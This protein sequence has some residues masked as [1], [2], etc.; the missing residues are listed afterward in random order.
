MGVVQTLKTEKLTET[1]G[2]DVLDVE[3]DRLRNDGDLPGAV[4]DAL[5]ELRRSGP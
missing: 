5:E 1:V 2:V 4:L 3:A